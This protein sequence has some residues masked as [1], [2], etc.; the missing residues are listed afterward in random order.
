MH[1][2]KF[3]RFCVGSFCP[4]TP[5]FLK[6][7]TQ[8]QAEVSPLVVMPAAGP[9]LPPAAVEVCGCQLCCSLCVAA[10]HSTPGREQ[11]GTS[12]YHFQRKCWCWTSRVRALLLL[13][14]LLLIFIWSLANH[15]P[16]VFAR[17]KNT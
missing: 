4:Q 16:S 10:E 15:L 3:C 1:S 13:P 7:T 11:L 2:G 12:R 6:P 14:P 17:C 5:P 8:P 9:R